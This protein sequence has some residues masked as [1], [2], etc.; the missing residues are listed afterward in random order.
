MSLSARLKQ[1]R[2]DLQ[3]TQG[4]FATKLGVSYGA[5]QKWEQEENASIRSDVIERIARQFG[6][7]PNWLV[8]GEGSPL[9]ISSQTLNDQTLISMYVPDNETGLLV[10]EPEAAYEWAVS[11]RHLREKYGDSSGLFFFQCTT[12]EMEPLLKSGDILIIDGKQTRLVAGGIYVVYLE[13]SPVLRSVRIPTVGAVELFCFNALY[14]GTVFSEKN[15]HLLNVAGRALC[16]R[17]SL[18]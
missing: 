17:R 9:L 8:L 14:S 15:R 5:Y 2:T 16:F 3:L 1:I 4:E 13:G 6:Y 7:S 18:I 12:A 10:R 11:T